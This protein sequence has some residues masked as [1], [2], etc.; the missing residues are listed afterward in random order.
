LRLCTVF[1][2]E[3]NPAT[4]FGLPPMTFCGA[5]RTTGCKSQYPV[6]RNTHYAEF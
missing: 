3:N 4:G 6:M 2:K 1:E 5:Q